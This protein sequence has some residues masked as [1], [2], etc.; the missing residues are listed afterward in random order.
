[1]SR[2]R[3]PHLPLTFS[4]IYFEIGFTLLPVFLSIS[5]SLVSSP[6]SACFVFRLNVLKLVIPLLN[7][8]FS[9]CTLN[10]MAL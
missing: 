10:K 7:W 1:M 8:E 6:R 9:I 5:Q 3:L 2:L 4:A